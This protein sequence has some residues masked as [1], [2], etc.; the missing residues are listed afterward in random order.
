MYKSVSIFTTIKLVFA[1]FLLASTAVS[2]KGAE[3]VV[4]EL[5]A[6]YEKTRTISKFSLNYHFFNKQYR[7]LD[8]WD[9]ASPDR[10]MSL[11]MVEVDLDKKH[12]YDNDILYA[13][14]G[15][16]LDRVQFQNDHH[17]YYYENNGN[18]LG[19]G[20]LN[21]GMGN[22][23][24]FMS[25]MSLN[26]DF[27]A[28]RPLLD[29]KD[30]DLITLRTQANSEFFTLTHSISDDEVE[31]EFKREPLRLVSIDKKSRKARYVY[32]DYQ[33]TRGLTFARSVN[34]FYNGDT[35][36]AYISFNDRFDIIS[37]VDSSKLQLPQGYGPE[38]QRGDGVLVMKEIGKNLYL[39]TDS[40]HARNSLLK[41]NGDELALFGGSGYSSLSGKTIKLITETFPNKKIASIH[42]THPHKSE[43]AGLAVFAKLG[44]EILADKY[45]IA[46]IKALPEFAADIDKIKFRV[47]E[48]GQEIEGVNFYVLSNIHTKE[49]SFAYFKDSGIIF[50]AD[51]LS[52]A[53]DNTIPKFI[54]SYTRAFIDFIRQEQLKYQRIVGHYR[55]NNI[56]VDVVNKVYNSMM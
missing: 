15:R 27:L 19:K 10:V 49:Q 31:Y 5:K 32:S 46:G 34:K 42:V 3:S 39:I 54:P 53:S 33:T 24:R 56:S 16:M 12:F 25:F 43:I 4:N 11:R 22:F 17:S 23:D 55:N 36:P 7:S 14:G 26:I 35:V 2:A 1:S 40:G 52:L 30:I 6:H 50:Q 38:I 48:S 29:E 28:V 45:T 44:V 20:Y 8:Y 13:P 9:F 47:I 51:F 41:V 18:F 21:L 37:Q